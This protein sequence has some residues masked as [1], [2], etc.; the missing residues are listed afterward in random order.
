MQAVI[1]PR[2]FR[3]RASWK[4]DG[5]IYQVIIIGLKQRQSQET[6][7]REQKRRKS[8]N[9]EPKCQL[10]T[11]KVNDHLTNGRENVTFPHENLK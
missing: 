6:T 9:R 8:Q 7:G 5:D 4:C 3:R 10:H 11:T 1:W 2:A